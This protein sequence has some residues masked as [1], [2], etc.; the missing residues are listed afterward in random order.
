MRILS[1]ASKLVDNPHRKNFRRIH[2][3][4]SDNV[5]RLVSSKVRKFNLIMAP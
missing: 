2:E 5:K 4:I 1:K 3:R